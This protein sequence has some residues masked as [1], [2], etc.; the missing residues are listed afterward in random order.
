MAKHPKRKNLK[1][2][3]KCIFC[4][5][6]GGS[7][8]PMSGE[9][10]WPEWMHPYLPR[11]E[12]PKTAASYTVVRKDEIQIKR[13]GPRHGHTF[14]NTIN[15]VCKRCNETW[16]GDIETAVKPILISVLQGQSITL[17]GGAQR[18][19]VN[20]IALKAMVIEQMNPADAVVRARARREF[21]ET[22]TIPRGMEILIATHNSPEFYNSYWHRTLRA[23][24]GRPI[25]RPGK[26][27]DI[28]STFLGVGHLFSLTFVSLIP[29]IKL[30]PKFGSDLVQRIWPPVSGEVQWPMPPI[31]TEVGGR[32]A[33]VLT[34]LIR[35]PFSEWSTI[36]H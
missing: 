4:G 32:L 19:L 24:L 26:F 12:N 31:S 22:R 30:E 2:P 1:P 8:N 29:E 16:M 10:I 23:Q 5:G 21:K 7:G 34:Q 13:H 33:E 25:A 6:G 9:H 18:R 3:R 28:Q 36:R 15:V 14:T 11:Q 20:W 17:D 35:A 27:K